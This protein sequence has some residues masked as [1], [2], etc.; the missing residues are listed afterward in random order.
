[1]IKNQI[2][3]V[4]SVS[5]S[6]LLLSAN[7]FGFAWAETVQSSDNIQI[8]ATDAIKKDP[9]MMKILYN[10]ELFKQQYA[11]LQ[12]KQDILAQQKSMIDA[13]RKVANSYLQADLASS[14]NL[15]DMTNP[16][17]AYAGF[18]SKVDSS[19]QNVFLSEFAYMQAKASQGKL[20]MSKVLQ[21]GGTKDQALNAYYGAASTQKTELV[22]VNKDINIKYQLADKTTQDLFNK[23]G[24]LKKYSAS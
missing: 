16:K 8:K 12:L 19:A 4:L 2:Q 24:N 18:V 3:V 6:V 10:I 11:A 7:Y 20:A 5:A 21:N 23:Y 22:S 13:Q 14:N 15:N 1:M 9:G 17:N